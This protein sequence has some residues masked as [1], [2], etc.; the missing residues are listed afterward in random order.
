MSPLALEG[1]G[2]AEVISSNGSVVELLASRPFPPGSTLSLLLA[3]GQAVRIK[4]RGSKR[5]SADEAERPYRVDGRFVD[6]TRAQR[7][8]LLGGPPGR[9]GG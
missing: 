9:E 2:T 6:L 7:E 5:V 8:S 1:S 3:E 4:V